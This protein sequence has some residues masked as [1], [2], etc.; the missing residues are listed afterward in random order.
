MNQTLNR[1]GTDQ[2]VQPRRLTKPK[3]TIKV[4]YQSK[5]NQF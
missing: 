5:M 4:E 2:V 1:A 3:P